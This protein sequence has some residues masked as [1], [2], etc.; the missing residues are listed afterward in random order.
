M[1]Y[2]LIKRIEFSHAIEQCSKKERH[3][4]NSYKFILIL[5]QKKRKE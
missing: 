3:R 1:S 4:E 2:F 5:I